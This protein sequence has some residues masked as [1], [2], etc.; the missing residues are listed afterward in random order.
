MS[1]L[2]KLIRV[3]K[4]I[5]DSAPHAVLLVLDATVGQNAHSTTLTSAPRGPNRR[6]DQAYT[7]NPT[8]AATGTII[9][10]A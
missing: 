10:R 6:R 7:S 8:P 5:D 1:E 4:K 3:I 9:M 2:Q